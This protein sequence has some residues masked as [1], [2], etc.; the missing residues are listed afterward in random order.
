M[1]SDAGSLM[2]DCFASEPSGLN[3]LD[4]DFGDAIG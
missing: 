4:S 3:V 2:A 1:P